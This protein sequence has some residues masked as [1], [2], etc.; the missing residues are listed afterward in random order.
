MAGKYANQKVQLGAES[1]KGSA[2][3]ATTIWR[4]HGDLVDDRNQ[5]KI[6]E[7]VGIAVPTNRI[8]V[9]ALL[10]KMTM[11]A[12]PA[13]FE[14]LPYILEAGIIKE[15][16]TQDGAGTDYIYV[17]EMGK[18]TVNTIRTYTI[19][20]GDDQNAE[21]MEYGVVESFT[22]S[23]KY[24]ELLQMSASWFGRQVAN[25]TFTGSLSVPSVEEIIAANGSLA[26]DDND[27]TMGS[28][29]I[30]AG[31][32][33]EFN[34]SVNTG[35]QP[36]FTIDSSQKY[37][38]EDTFDRQ[39]FA[40]KLGMTWR[41]SADAKLERDNWRSETPRMIRLM[42]Q[43]SAV[44][45]PGTTYSVLTLLIDMVGVYTKFNAIENDSGDSIVKAEFDIGY[46]ETADIESLKITVVNELAAL[47]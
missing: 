12:T 23:G 18:T 16:P 46:D 45:T 42:F 38:Y 43:G 27:G 11:P 24:G 34:L 15:T 13:T 7:K 21:E 10:G 41:H 25:T 5:I 32:L 47:P 22:L 35:R 37:F 31:S 2:V 20:S 6:P 36:R 26:I 3:A 8:A 29:S 30:A 4:G 28:T 40:A 39:Q 1:T 17:Y 19:E 44:G 33:L 9:G 14:Q